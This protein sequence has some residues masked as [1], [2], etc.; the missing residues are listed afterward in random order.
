[1]PGSDDDQDMSLGEAAQHLT[2][3]LAG[4][5]VPGR[6]IKQSV[7]IAAHVLRD[8]APTVPVSQPIYQ[9]QPPDEEKPS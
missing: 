2:D 8:A 3:W 4:R 7:E 5:E 6:K 1:M 9:Y